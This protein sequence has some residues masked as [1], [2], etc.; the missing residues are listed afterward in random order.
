MAEKFLGLARVLIVEDNSIIAGTLADM[1]EMMGVQTIHMASTISEASQLLQDRQL[2]L[3]VVDLKL[4]DENGL[5]VANECL[6][7]GVPVIIS[8]GHSDLA[9]PLAYPSE[10]LLAK[11]Y[12]LKDLNGAVSNIFTARSAVKTR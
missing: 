7:R 10:Q 12:T 2:D 8:T 3:A 1:F 5:V 6:N 4:G 11:P 9:L